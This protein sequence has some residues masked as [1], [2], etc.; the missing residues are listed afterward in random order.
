MIPH[1]ITS[2]YNSCWHHYTPKMIYGDCKARGKGYASAICVKSQPQ[3]GMP[4]DIFCD[5]VGFGPVTKTC[6]AARW[7]AAMIFNSLQVVEE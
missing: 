6:G 7:I 5:M 2:T 1:I 3:Y 4:G